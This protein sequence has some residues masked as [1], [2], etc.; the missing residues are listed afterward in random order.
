MTSPQEHWQSEEQA[1]R[2][3]RQ[4]GLAS[5]FV[6]AP[7]A[8]KIMACLSSADPSPTIVDL[9]CGP[10]LLGVELAKLRPQARIIGVDPSDEM[11]RIAKANASKVG[12]T[13]YEAK[14][15]NAEEIPL[16]SDAIDLVVSQSSL[17]EWEDPH[18]GLV[19]I[20]RVLRPGGSLILKDYNLSWL[21]PW[22]RKLLR[23]FH[24]LD[25][26]KF[27]FDDAA[28]MAR[29]AGFE[30]IEAGGNGLQYFLRATKRRE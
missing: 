2:Y 13:N 17:H 11:L 4:L 25:M 14:Q 24:S 15:G 20:H 3:S 8:R 16:E 21:A 29:E 23:S 10:G 6:Y 9:G 18:R 1:Q 27:G 5:R 28:S 7:F 30:E 22:K 12:L 19:E 26:F